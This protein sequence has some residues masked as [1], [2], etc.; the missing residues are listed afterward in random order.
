MSVEKDGVQGYEYQYLCSILIVLNLL[1]ANKEVES[2]EIEKY[3]DAYLRIM[4]NMQ[5]KG[6]YFQG[7]KHDKKITLNDLSIWLSHYGER[8]TE[9]SLLER[10][11]KENASLIIFSYGRCEDS[12]EKLT[13]YDETKYVNSFSASKEF[14]EKLK[15]EILCSMKDVTDIGKER[16]N[17]M[18]QFLNDVKT[19]DLKNALNRICI[20]E[21]TTIDKVELLIADTLN[22]HFKI[23][24]RDVCDAINMLDKCIRSGRDTGNNIK[25]DMLQVI[26]KYAYNLLKGDCEYIIPPQ[27]HELVDTLERNNVLLITGV[28][29]CGK[30]ITA[31]FI[32]EKYQKRGFTI[33][34]K[35]EVSGDNSAYSFICDSQFDDYKLVIISDPFGD[36]EKNGKI[37]AVKQKIETIINN[38]TDQYRKVIITTRKDI[39]LESYNKNNLQECSISGNNWYDLSM[40]DLEYAKKIWI[41]LYKENNDSNVLFSK[42]QKLLYKDNCTFLE[43]GE[44]FHLHANY[45]SIEKL[46]DFSENEIINEARISADDI[47][48]RIKSYGADYVNAY[49]ALGLSCNSVR[50]VTINDLGFILSSSDETP[51]IVERRAMGVDVFGTSKHFPFPS[52]SI[53][54]ELS[55]KV[56]EILKKFRDCGY[57]YIYTDS[58]S[59]IVFS[60][61]IYHFVSQRLFENEMQDILSNKEYYS[62]LVKRCISALNKNINIVAL[63]AIEQ[64]FAK[65]KDMNIIDLIIISL[66]SIFPATKDRALRILEDNYEYLKEE[67]TKTFINALEKDFHNIHL[68]WKDNEPYYNCSDK[69]GF[70]DFYYDN[71]VD[72]A[73]EATDLE[74]IY[75][76]LSS[77][78]NSFDLAF[79]EKAC[80]FD[81]SM[82]RRLAF[83]KII[84]IYEKNIN[85]DDYLIDDENSNVII[86]IIQAAFDSWDLLLDEDKERIIDYFDRQSNKLPVLLLAQSFIESGNNDNYELRKITI[87]YLEAWCKI[88]A[89]YLK[90]CP[91]KYIKIDEY[92][93]SSLIDQIENNHKSLDENIILEFIQSWKTWLDKDVFPTDYGL[94]IMGFL[95]KTVSVEKRFDLFK[96]LLSCKKTNYLTSHIYYLISGWTLL[97]KQEQNEVKNLVLSNRNDIIWIKAIILNSREIPKDVL[98]LIIGKDID[99]SDVKGFVEILRTKQLLEPC[100]NVFCGYPQPLWWLGYHHKCKE[101]WNS[102]IEEVLLSE[103]VDDR[104]YKI[105]LREYVN[106]MYNHQNIY[107]CDI[108]E[109]IMRTKKKRMLLFDELLK[110]SAT[111]TQNNKKMWMD[112]FNACENEELDKSI[113]IIIENI[114]VINY[115]LSLN[116]EIFNQFDEKIFFDKIYPRL[117]GGYSIFTSCNDLKTIISVLENILKD[118]SNDEYLFEDSNRTPS[119][120]I[121]KLKDS[122]I[123]LIKKRYKDNPPRMLFTNQY[124]SDTIKRVKIE[125]KEIDKIIEEHRLLL[126]K[127]GC[128]MMDKFDDYYKLNNWIE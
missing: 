21:Q 99:V 62:G 113:N 45:K 37:T 73:P 117:N 109:D 42:I 120:Y 5:S 12:I 63:N 103:Y 71:E 100:L 2:I 25:D 65:T 53:K 55:P 40:S 111:Q 39:L 83:S 112:Y 92:K 41:S 78:N 75:K 14:Y 68:C 81:E 127:K 10:L 69:I 34:E 33:A 60:H 95:I 123:Q 107:S 105:A 57:I 1:K 110:V 91:V 80:K 4:E 59:K 87:S 51:G 27:F 50:F 23:S 85:I 38:H 106:A 108:W 36:Y 15:S 89:I 76:M 118:S 28:P 125:D 126:L 114:E 115:H 56:K 46:Q 67:Q 58:T 44:I 86:G 122:F 72:K 29:F 49:I 79:L 121:A 11:V 64:Y 128:S 70:G 3:E 13:E 24:K 98:S 124:L 116:N 48:S 17:N 84:K 47:I 35:D 16:K 101:R 119:Q 6:I 9:N 20:C 18:E 93:I 31:R 94:Y 43:A 96:A 52:Y 32:A 90:K 77:N 26:S 19:K 74:S 30:T 104:S 22:K 54:P 8:Q 66:N 7:K 102:I 97:S 82:I 61:P 88:T